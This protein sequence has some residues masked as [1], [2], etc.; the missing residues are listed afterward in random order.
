MK[1]FK[2]F[3]ALLTVA[4]LVMSMG[5]GAMATAPEN[6]VNGADYDDAYFIAGAESVDLI[7][8]T[9]NAVQVVKATSYENN[10][11]VVL[12]VEKRNIVKPVL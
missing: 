9:F 6:P 2:R 10:E 1:K 11:Y 12:K 4:V 3:L 5:M 7:G 8:H